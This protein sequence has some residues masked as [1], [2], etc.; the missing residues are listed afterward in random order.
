MKHLVCAENRTREL[1]LDRSFAGGD[2]PQDPAREPGAVHGRV[3]EAA[4]AGHRH[5][6]VQGHDAVHAHPPAQGQVHRQQECHRCST[7]FTGTQH[8]LYLLNIRHNIKYTNSVYL[9]MGLY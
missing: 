6:A 2:V 8:P 1:T 4:A 7:N 3:H 5:V 9:Y